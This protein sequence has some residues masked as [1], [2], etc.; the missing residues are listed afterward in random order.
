MRNCFWLRA[1]TFTYLP[2]ISTDLLKLHVVAEN[3]A[4]LIDK[5]AVEGHPVAALC[6]VLHIFVFTGH[7]MAT[8]AFH[9]T[10]LNRGAKLNPCAK[11]IIY[12]KILQLFV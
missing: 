7:L 4:Y 5:R 1:G 12:F 10:Y 11:I 8:T 2:I 3:G 9:S 6:Q